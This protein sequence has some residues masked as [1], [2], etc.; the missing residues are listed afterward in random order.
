MK[1]FERIKHD[2]GMTEEDIRREIYSF[3][4]DY[5]VVD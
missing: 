3:D 2:T 4:I 5:Y 1:E